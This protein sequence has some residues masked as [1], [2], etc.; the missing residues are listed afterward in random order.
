MPRMTVPLTVIT[1]PIGLWA[2][3]LLEQARGFTVRA[4]FSDMST[5]GLILVTVIADR[6]RGAGPSAS[7]TFKEMRREMGAAT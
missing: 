5:T 1:G 6:C 4:A 2:G 7:T 3:Y